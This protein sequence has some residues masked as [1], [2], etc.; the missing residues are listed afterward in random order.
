MGS[1]GWGFKPS[2]SDS[3]TYP[4][5]SYA[6]NSQDVP[7]GK[8]TCTAMTAEPTSRYTI[9]A[10][11]ARRKH[12]GVAHPTVCSRASHFTPLGGRLPLCTTCT[13]LAQASPRG[14]PTP[15]QHA[16][17]PGPPARQKNARG[18]GQTSHGQI[19]ASTSWVI[20]LAS[21]SSSVTWGG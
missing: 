7:G 8:E 13:L 5:T 21:V 16:T 10:Y 2:M 12:P 20:Y 1:G 19:S 3:R 4:L 9:P 14:P 17:A 18:C 6:G 11:N 15:Q